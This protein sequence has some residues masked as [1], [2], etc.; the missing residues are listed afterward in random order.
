MP[1]FGEKVHFQRWTL[2]LWII[3]A[4]GGCTSVEFFPAAD[5][6]VLRRSDV[7]E[8]EIRRTAPQRSWKKLG[9]LVVRDASGDL[10]DPG[11]RAFLEA[12]ARRRGAEGV[13]IQFSALDRST[14]LRAG[15]RQSDGYFAGTGELELPRQS[16]NIILFN[17]DA[18]SGDGM[19]R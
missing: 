9:R 2:A 19:N 6:P 16:L 5:Y 11:F 3:F 1:E 10:S 12:E 7:G 17:Y 8:V 15:T 13:W 14:T 4:A 18:P